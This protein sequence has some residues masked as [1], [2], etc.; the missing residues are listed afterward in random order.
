MNNPDPVDSFVSEAIENAPPPNTE[1]IE[2]EKERQKASAYA[3]ADLR[4]RDGNPFDPTLHRTG[5]DGEPILSAAGNLQRKPGR[6]GG[7][8]K[9]P[10]ESRLNVP[11][12]AVASEGGQDSTAVAIATVD[13]IQALGL[14]IGGDEW[15]YQRDE[16]IGLDERAQGISA[17]KNFFD[18]QGVVDIPPGLALAIW[19]ASYAVPRFFRPKTRSRLKLGWEWARVKLLRRRPRENAQSDNRHDR[20]REDDASNPHVAGIRGPRMEGRGTGPVTGH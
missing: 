9:R 13:G 1:A 6:R 19:G 8:A 14:M 15:A 17:F 12:G 5:P 20:K 16:K 7:Q 4:D 18:A 10:T 11:G 2:A 3:T